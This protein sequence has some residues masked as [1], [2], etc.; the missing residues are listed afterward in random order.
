MLEQRL[1]LRS[2]VIINEGC[3]L[4]MT[5]EG[6]DHVLILCGTPSGEAFEIVVQ[7]QALRALIE[8][9]NDALEKIDATEEDDQLTTE[10]VDR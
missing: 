9:G 4:A 1:V 3:P 8:L 2:Y 5:A 6:P 7:H 10:L